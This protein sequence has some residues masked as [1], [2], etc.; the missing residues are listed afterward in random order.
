M[1]DLGLVISHQFSSRT[2]LLWSLAR[3]ARVWSIRNT[4]EPPWLPPP[5]RKTFHWDLGPVLADFKR[6]FIRQGLDRYLAETGP[7]LFSFDL[8]PSAARHE[9]ILPLS[10]PLGPSAIRR[11]TESAITFIRRY[12]QGPLAAENYNF[13]PTGLYNQVTEADFIDGYLKEFDLGLVLDLAHGAVTA[14][15]LGLAPDAYLASLPLERTMEIHISRPWLPS[16][17][18]LWAVDAHEPPQDREWV[19]LENLLKNRRLPPSVPV[20]VEYYRDL[21]KLEKAQSRLAALLGHESP[22][23]ADFA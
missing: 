12:Y 3:E 13:Y 16:R 19:W 22:P 20:F 18:G 17:A 6:S 1:A 11:R 4:A 23:E 8:G 5:R 14:H 9:G 15:N 7:A 21:G 10:P 2:P